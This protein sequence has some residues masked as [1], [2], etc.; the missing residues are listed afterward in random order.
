MAYR[1]LCRTSLIELRK[2]LEAPDFYI[3]E[4]TLGS[5]FPDPTLEDKIERLT[6]HLA[7]EHEK[8]FDLSR[9]PYQCDV[10]DAQSL[11]DKSQPC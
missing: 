7:Y 11:R 4:L 2:Q 6:S 9:S 5:F 3:M 10:N 8:D 1:S